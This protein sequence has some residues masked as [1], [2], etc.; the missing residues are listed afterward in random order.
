MRKESRVC[1]PHNSGNC[2]W[3]ANHQS[4]Q[5]DW[6][7]PSSHSQFAETTAPPS[8]CYAPHKTGKFMLQQA[9][10]NLIP[11]FLLLWFWRPAGYQWTTWQA[12]PPKLAQKTPDHASSNYCSLG[13]LKDQLL[14]LVKDL[15]SRKKK[16]RFVFHLY[17]FRTISGA[18]SVKN[19]VDL[20]IKLELLLV[21]FKL[22][23]SHLFIQLRLCLK[24]LTFL[25]WLSSLDSF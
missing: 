6:C 15:F 19:G 8:E 5:G 10:V 18:N 16:Q 11:C 1:G 9:C 3:L 2:E 12:N 24:L 17:I 20:S 7:N 4:Q 14:P 22:H 23:L 13:V 25:V 21:F